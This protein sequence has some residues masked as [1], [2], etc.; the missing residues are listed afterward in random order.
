[1]KKTVVFFT[2]IA[3]IILGWVVLSHLHE[4][5]TLWE[6][7]HISIRDLQEVPA[8][9]ERLLGTVTYVDNQNKRFWL[10]DD[11]GAISIDIEPGLPRIEVGNE[12]LVRATKT[13]SFDPV[14]GLQSLDLHLEQV[15]ILREYTALPE[16][17]P[18]TV[19]TFPD[20]DK[21]GLRV[22]VE[23][24]LH[25]IEHNHDGLDLLYFG[26]L[27]QEL[28]AVV[29]TRSDNLEHSINSKLRITGVG[30]NRLDEGGSVQARYIWVSRLQDVQKIDDPPSSMQLYSVRGLYEF[31][32]EDGGHRILLGGR[33]LRQ[34]GPRE[35]TVGDQWGAVSCESAAPVSFAPGDAVEVAGFPRRNG[36]RV[37]LA[38][39]E[40]KRQKILP[41]L[42][43]VE[44]DIRVLTKV[45][46]VR[47]LTEYE[48][49]SARPVR[50]TGV[51][52]FND[53]DWQQLFLQD[54]TGGIFV[55]YGGHPG[56]RRGD[57]ITVIGLTNP[58]DYAPI[59]VAPKVVHVGQ[60]K[61]PAPVVMTADAWSGILDGTLVE[62]EGIVHP[63]KPRQNPKH[64]TFD[65]YTTFGT[66]HV[67]AGPEFGGIESIR[68]L[69]DSKVRIMGVGS[70]I[71]NSRRQ[72]I[73]LQIVISR[74]SDIKVLEPGLADPFEGSA[75]PISN[76]LRFSPTT[77]FGHRIKVSGVVTM[78]GDHFFYVQD[79]TG[80]ARI[81]TDTNGINISDIVEV[82]GYPAPN[83]YS[84]L[85]MDSVVRITGHDEPT[86][87]RDVTPETLGDGRFDSQLV[88]IEG[89]L[90]GVVNSPDSVTFILHSDERSVDAILYVLNSDEH[91]S[92][93][94][95]GSVLRLTGI[96]S[97]PV[98]NNS[99]YLLLTKARVGA[100]LIVRSPQ[101]IQ[102][103]KA[104]SWWSV[105]RPMLIAIGLLLAV[106]TSLLWI[107]VLGRRIQRQRHELQKATEKNAAINDFIRV[108]QDV[109]RN[110]RFTSRVPVQG[111]DEIALLS[112]EFNQMLGELHIRDLQKTEAESKLQHQAL[113]DD[114]TGLPNRRLLSDRLSQVLE[115]AK[116]DNRIVALLYLDL[117]GFKLVN[118]SLGHTVGDSLLAEVAR[119]LGS[120]IRKS[121]TLARLGGDEFTVVLTKLN[122]PEEAALVANSLLEV[123]SRPFLIE[124]HEITISASIGI[125]IFPLNGMDAGELLQQADSAMYSAK[126][127]GKNRIMYFTSELGLSVRERLNLENQLRTALVKGEITVHYQPEFDIATRRLVRF[128]ALARWQHPT[129]G[130]IT[131]DRFIPIAEESGLIIPLG[132]F[133][134]EQACRE[135]V[136]WQSLGEGSIQ[137]AVNVSTVQFRRET[138]V[139][140]VEAALK[141][142]GLDPKLL[143]LELTESIML[144]GTERASNTMKKLAAMGVSIAVDDFGTGYSCFSYLPRLPFN[145]LKI[146][147]AFVSELGKRTEMTAMIRSLVTLAHNLNMQVVVEGVETAQ[148]LATIEAL[149]GNEVQGYLL[150]RPTPDPK[151]FLTSSSGV[152]SS[153]DA[154]LQPLVDQSGNSELKEKANAQKGSA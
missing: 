147:R 32:Q 39:S 141:T 7:D 41:N 137:V 8:G 26:E 28:V 15:R 47:R 21:N 33:V 17:A 100:K 108:I 45:S 118:D 77:R 86:T 121:D 94:R 109:T 31:R 119:R 59:I 124:N 90:T 38:H 107:S 93:P 18:A 46:A 103:L 116:R 151:A 123:L 66:V 143:Q 146:D 130:N 58:G 37:D 150:G 91:V 82:A 52:T 135:A 132:T 34:D 19:N 97:V 149:G 75:V 85:L 73:G 129:L 87:I 78:V 57:K 9:P 125:S 134:L 84:P 10:Q 140:E 70:V 144:D 14:I 113:T 61:L 53:D 22:V 62:A 80:G 72:M 114:L 120:R 36:L 63:I 99:I 50:L 136:T 110:K 76:L 1:M 128:E 101:D 35:L 27:G 71:F 95:E 111:A 83:G 65:V 51:V 30:E 127:D 67:V 5:G 16:P 54:S 102:V 105:H 133:V 148:Q 69:E 6:P 92:I 153:Q 81:E 48:A 98:N 154:G 112:T 122:S 60:E 24:V 20:K 104:V 23:G 13:R 3:T 29:P 142:S 68:K 49:S 115:M 43:A 131:P 11:T 55:K 2:L 96:C 56:V 4:R 44:P 145:T 12:L 152:F 126:R 88:S 79:G 138:F 40:I 106:A 25:A 139:D 89:T 74:P 117:D 42:L 64:L